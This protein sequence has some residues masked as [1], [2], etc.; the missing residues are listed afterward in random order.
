MA[1]R[2]AK[3]AGLFGRLGADSQAGTWTLKLGVS[4]LM[5]FGN[6]LVHPQSHPE[7]MN[8]QQKQF[9]KHAKCVSGF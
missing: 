2:M 5:P 8:M 1:L 6:D 3:D 9:K 4:L 7:K